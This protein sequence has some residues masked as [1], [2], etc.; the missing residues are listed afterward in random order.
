MNLHAEVPSSPPAELRFRRPITPLVA[1]RELWQAREL[2]RALVERQLR[3]RY[4]QAFLGFAWAVIPPVSMMVVMTFFISKAVTIE[5]QGV[6]YPLFSYV[7]LLAWNFFTSSVTAG[8]QS[9]LGNIALLNKV[10]CP[11]E[12]F[13]VASAVTAG[14]DATIGLSVLALL[15]VGHDFVPKATAVW[16][17]VL[18]VVLV[19]FTLGV[20]LTL[21]ALVVYLRDLRYM[22]GMITQLGLLATPIAY[23]M[24]KIPPNLRLPYSAVNPLAPV[25]DGLRRTVLLGQPPVWDLLL[26]G[27]TTSFLLLGVGFILFK[28]L[29][30]GFVD[31]A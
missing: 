12:V 13:P 22:V 10:Y 11:R 28:K 31:V 1:V 8:S 4:K 5:T 15:F 20:A 25:I 2:V 6:P 9:L 18:L 24:N 17:P 30:T 16:V 7:A 27:A 23:G 26:A 3:S 19:A 21:S 14:V 29:E